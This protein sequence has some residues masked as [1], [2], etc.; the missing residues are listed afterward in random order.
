MQRLIDDIYVSTGLRSQDGAHFIQAISP[1]EMMMNAALSLCAPQMF[2]IGSHAIDLIKEGDCLHAWHEHVNLWPSAFSGIE[3][4]V[5]RS[6]PAHRDP[7]ASS[8]T[9]DLLV[10]AGT[11]T[12]SSIHIYDVNAN[13]EY[14]PGTIVLLCGRVLKHEVLS[15]NGGER[16]CIA[17]YMWD[18]V[19]QR[20]NLPR[21]DW[22][23]IDTYR[24]LMDSAFCSRVYGND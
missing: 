7:G 19:H 20:L 22:V 21:P 11:H 24:D 9:F 3:A 6:T 23:S 17:H 8:S 5:N 15:W 2:A 18:N 4:I 13:L 12:S 1:V 16:I 10:S 14:Q